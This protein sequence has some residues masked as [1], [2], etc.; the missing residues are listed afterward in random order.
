MIFPPG[1]GFFSAGGLSSRYRAVNS[2]PLES[3]FF[4]QC[5]PGTMLNSWAN[6]YW[7]MVTRFEGFNG[8]ILDEIQE[9]Q[10]DQ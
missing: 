1:R 6:H 5:C 9:A 4:K 2:A 10:D 8:R 3:I 7:A